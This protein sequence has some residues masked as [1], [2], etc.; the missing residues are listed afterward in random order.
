[1]IPVNLILNILAACAAAVVA[2]PVDDAS[3]SVLMARA[4]P[5]VYMCEDKDWKGICR[6]KRFQTETCYNVPGELVARISSI[7]NNDKDVNTCT[8]YRESFLIIN[9]SVMGSE[10]DC[11]GDTYR[12]QDDGNLGDGNAHF[13]DSIRSFEC[14]RK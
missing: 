4:E 2:A 5:S 13:N 10:R 6:T 7:R 1:M 8:W 12:N 3:G 14:R 9:V 11:R